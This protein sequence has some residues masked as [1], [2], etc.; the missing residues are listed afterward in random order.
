MPRKRLLGMTSRD[1]DHQTL[2]QR[3]SHSFQRGKLGVL[4]VILDPRNG[5]LLGLEAN[6]PGSDRGQG[7][8]GLQG[9]VDGDEPNARV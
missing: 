2:A 4:G 8:L 3:R 6:C 9:K 5:G 1:L 7:L